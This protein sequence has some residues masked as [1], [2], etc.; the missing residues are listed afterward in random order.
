MPPSGWLS[1]GLSSW[2]VP[3]PWSDAFGTFLKATQYATDAERYGCVRIPGHRCWP[4]QIEGIQPQTPW[5]VGVR[6]ATWRSP[7]GPGSDVLPKANHPVVHV[8]W[9][10][11]VAYADWAG[12]RLPTE[13][14]WE[15][16]GAAE[17]TTRSTRGET[18]SPA[19]PAPLQ[20]LAGAS[21]CSTWCR[22][23]TARDLA[24]GFLPP[25]PPEGSAR[26]I[27]GGPTYATPRTATVAGSRPVHPIPRRTTGHTGFRCAADLS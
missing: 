25:Q 24:G 18:S 6:G 15:K 22:K 8:S 10:E 3:R 21:R 1:R 20:H 19:W 17:S 9:H 16:S 2:P 23:N 7:D 5:W 13:A 26:V 27:R 4:V 11:T 12:K 14:K